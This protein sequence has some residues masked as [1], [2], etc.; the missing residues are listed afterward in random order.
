MKQEFTIHVLGFQEDGLWCALALDLSLRGYGE[1]F[2]AA[3][4]DLAHAVEAQLSFAFQ[5]NTLDKIWQPA[6]SRY[7]EMYQDARRHA[8]EK[9]MRD[10]TCEQDI[11]ALG[12]FPLPKPRS[13]HFSLAAAR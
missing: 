8:L 1:T 7:Y 5:H 4:Q 10:E 12:Y 9:S 13:E 2:E 11:F 3:Q 6:E